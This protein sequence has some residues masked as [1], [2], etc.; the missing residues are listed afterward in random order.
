MRRS[1]GIDLG[2]VTWRKSSYSNQE[3]GDCL[4]V[5]NTFPALIPVRDS[6][7][8]DGPVLLF[9]APAWACFVGGLRPSPEGAGDRRLSR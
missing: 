6:K 2:S 7:N 5:A 1:K 9:P 4:E 3:G 8:P